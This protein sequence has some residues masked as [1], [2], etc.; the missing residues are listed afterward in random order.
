MIPR[1]PGVRIFLTALAVVLFATSPGSAQPAGIAKLGTVEGI[2]E[3]RLANGLRMLLIPDAS[4][5]KV[6]VNI[7][8]AGVAARRRSTST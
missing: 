3:Y 1:P 7:R 5:P 8:R 4:P 6:T 2:T